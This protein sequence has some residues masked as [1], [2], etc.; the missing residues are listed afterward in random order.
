MHAAHDPPGTTAAHGIAMPLARQNIAP[1]I[2]L[3]NV[4]SSGSNPFVL[5]RGSAFSSG[6]FGVVNVVAVDVGE[7]G[8]VDVAGGVAGVAGVAGVDGA[9]AGSAIGGGG[10]ATV[11]GVVES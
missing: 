3:T 11:D 2:T 5:G 7:G 6:F 8:A 4:V 10:D 9:S 1:C